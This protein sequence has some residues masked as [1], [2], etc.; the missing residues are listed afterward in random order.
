MHIRVFVITQ[1]FVFLA[2]FL[3]SKQSYALARSQNIPNG[4]CL[5]LNSTSQQFD[6]ILTAHMAQHV[7]VLENKFNFLTSNLLYF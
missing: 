3:R 5:L 2:V 6:I 7:F 1:C 4:Y